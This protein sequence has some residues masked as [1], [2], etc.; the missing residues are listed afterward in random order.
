MFKFT[1]IVVRPESTPKI[2]FVG[3]REVIGSAD[4]LLSFTN[5]VTH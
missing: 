1:L 4:F 5:I 3:Y 2:T